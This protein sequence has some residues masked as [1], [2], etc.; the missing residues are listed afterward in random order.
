MPDWAM[1]PFTRP[2]AAKAQPVISPNPASLFKDPVTQQPVKWEALHT[3]NPAAI[4]RNGKIH[5]LYR[6]EDDSGEMTIGHH[7]SR[8]GLAVSEDGVNFT[9]R[10]TPIFFP[11]NDA[12]KDNEW[13]GGC[14]DPRIVESEDGTYV[15]TYTQ[16]NRNRF[17]VGIAT[18]KDLEHW[19]K[20]GQAFERTL[21]GKYKELR[22]KSAG[23]VT[24]VQGDRLIAAKI[25][26]KY[27]M[28][29][30]EG[31]LHLATSPD[32]INW[33]PV[34]DADGKLV[35]LIGPRRGKFDSTF[36]EVGPPPIVTDRGILVLY[37]GKN[38]NTTGDKSLGPEAYA[39]G[40]ALFDIKDP[41]KLI[42]QLDSPFFKPEL[43][44]EMRGQYRSGTT[45][46]EGLVLYKN[47]W[48]LYYGCAD[49]LVGVTVYD[50]AQK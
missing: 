24:K 14:E 31:T 13:P 39:A 34:E 40:Q 45:F 23:I 12:Q 48:F 4:V 26:G 17:R 49:S 21:G 29:W 27:W 22:Y 25:D 28:Y 32:L 1:V 50:P 20:H 10:P 9:R 33:S 46:I 42:G 7:T 41:S 38:A 37:N 35:S 47:K 6:A 30:G 15:L 16:W 43:P 18:S 3:F 19:T 36:P 44:F 2:A 8:L 5:V 11:D